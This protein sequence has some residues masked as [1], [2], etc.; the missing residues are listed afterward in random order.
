MA[1]PGVLGTD[2]CWK[3]NEYGL[4]IRSRRALQIQHEARAGDEL[5]KQLS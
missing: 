1:A 5:R 2:F 3:R 4:T